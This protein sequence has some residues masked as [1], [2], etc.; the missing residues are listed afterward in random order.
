MLTLYNLFA[1]AL[2]LLLYQQ[3]QIFQK[4]DPWVKKTFHS[5]VPEDLNL[6]VQNILVLFRFIENK[7]FKK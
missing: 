4:S 7:N 3:H 1:Q 2:Q 6:P 5:I